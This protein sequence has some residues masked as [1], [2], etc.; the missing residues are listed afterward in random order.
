M[1]MKQEIPRGFL[2]TEI[3]SLERLY[4]LANQKKEALLRDDHQTLADLVKEEEKEV[5]GLET[6]GAVGLG[7]GSVPVELQELFE[8][9]TDLVRKI[10]EVNSFNRQLIEDSLAY[11]RFFIQSLQ[12]ETG[13]TIYGSTG[14]VKSGAGNALIDLRG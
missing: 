12:G 4:L 5:Q 14:A 2:E 8:K 3:T 6:G 1:E 10:Q 11:I 7:G 13:R 9:R